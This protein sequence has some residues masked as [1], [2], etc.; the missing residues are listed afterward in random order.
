MRSFPWSLKSG[1]PSYAVR[2]DDRGW[3]AQTL[4]LVS[5]GVSG[6]A[7]VVVVTVMRVF[8]ARSWLWSRYPT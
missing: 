7:R 2:R 4:D 8:S 6:L 1:P 5:A 3:R